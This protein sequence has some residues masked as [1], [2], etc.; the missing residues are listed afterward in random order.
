MVYLPG[1]VV[2]FVSLAFRRL[3]TGSDAWFVLCAVCLAIWRLSTGV[4]AWFVVC[5]VSLASWRLFTS[6]RAWCV[7]SALSWATWRLFTGVALV[8][9]VCS[10]FGLWALVLQCVFVYCVLDVLIHFH[11]RT[12][13]VCCVCGVPDLLALV[14]RCARSVLCFLALG[15]QCARPVCCACGVAYHRPGALM[16]I[17]RDVLANGEHRT[18]NADA[19]CPEPLCLRPRAPTPVWFVATDVQCALSAE[20]TPRS[21]ELIVVQM[22][23]ENPVTRG[24]PRNRNPL[25]AP[26]VPHSPQMVLH[27]LD[28]QPADTGHRVVYQHRGP[29]WLWEQLTV[30]W[31]SA[32]RH[33]T[34][35]A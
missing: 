18:P 19:V 32:S 21:S 3:F 16:Y 1:S 35:E 34:A 6:V 23:A 13:L 11:R 5:V 15:N 26:G 30:L 31:S 4:R 9:S 33:T 10:V 22:G 24:L 7:V 20:Q 8:C 27:A 2:C 25:T 12:R 29:A 14:H 28:D 17:L